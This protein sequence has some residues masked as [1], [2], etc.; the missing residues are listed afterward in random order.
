MGHQ[1]T[2]IPDYTL[3]IQLGIFFATYFVLRLFVFKPYLQ[4][5]KLRENQG[6]GLKSKA[7]EDRERAEQLR[8]QYEAFMLA[9]RKRVAAWA[10]QQRHAVAAEERRVVEEARSLAAKELQLVREKTG[11]ELGRAH[12]ELTPLVTEFSSAIASK[13]LGYQVKVSASSAESKKTAEA[14]HRV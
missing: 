9:E 13:L 12:E 10:D 14:E 8:Q 7:E 11:E 3:L 5:L 6:V 4:L 1:P 2:L